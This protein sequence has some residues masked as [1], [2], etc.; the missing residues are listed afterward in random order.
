MIQ[1][2]FHEH[3]MRLKDAA[4]KKK[5]DEAILRHQ[6]SSAEQAAQL[7]K[8]NLRASAAEQNMHFFKDD[9]TAAVNAG[10]QHKNE[11]GNL[12][13][14]VDALKAE[15]KKMFEDAKV[16]SIGTDEATLR[17]I[18]SELNKK[19]A[20]MEKSIALKNQHR[21][22]QA[23]ELEY[24]QTANARYERQVQN[25]DDAVS[26]PSCMPNKRTARRSPVSPARRSKTI[27]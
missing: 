16:L 13:R 27:S 25:D 23:K 6:Q 21:D 15:Q 4:C 22:S 2:N 24:H 7:K 1:L 18:I 14:Q 26:F 5:L 20:E 3:Q 10:I 12:K 8:A 9:Q 11:V 17:C 19:I